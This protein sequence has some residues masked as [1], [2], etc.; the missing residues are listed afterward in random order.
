MANESSTI[1]QRLWNYCNVLRD[2]GVS[3]GDYVEQLTYLLFLKMAD[4]QERELKKKS[5]IPKELNWQSL[6]SKDGDELE[7]HYRRILESLGKEK[8]L[9]GVIFRKSQNKIQDPAKLKRLVELINA[10]TWVGLDIDVKGEIYEGLLEKNAEDTKS[11]AGQYF[12]PRA[13]IKAM[14]A[15]MKPKPKMSICDPAC[16]TGGF[17]LSAHDY[18]SHNYKLDKEEKE[19][20]KFKT[21]KGKDIVDAVVRL[22]AMNLYL[23]GTGGEES[24]IESSDSLAAEPSEHFDMVL[25]N[26]PFGKKSAVTIVNGE[27]KAEKEAL[28]YERPD[29]WATTSNKQLNFLQH[30]K[31][32]LKINGRAA[33]VVPDNVLF[34][35]GAGE[36]VRRK[37]LAECDVHT[38]LRLPT[39]ISYAQGVKAN[40]LFF[41]RKPASEKSWTEK[42]W[43]YDLRTN[44]HFTLKTSTLKLD[45]LQDFITCYNPDNR[46]ER[47][48]SKRFKCFTYDE[49]V[50]RDK[51]SLDIFW[52]KDES[53]EDAANL[54]DPDVIANEIAENLGAALEQFRGITEER[55]RQFAN[56]IVFPRRT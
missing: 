4:E 30:V 56:G 28:V 18:L 6:L 33:I 42:L 1:V 2:D 16:G 48:E 31:S 51:A 47:K 53:L 34:E 54:P 36:T 38:L 43:I 41:D 3:Y 14:V 49:L 8:G 39:G 29:F 7:R 10:E 46:H 15:V 44:K 20:L 21:F 37:L 22:C 17:F 9:L 25:T 35:G 11:G 24:P 13:L 23:H 27:G 40:V 12:T 5:S 45:D 55:D 52:L 19:F 32:L 50:Q 26:P